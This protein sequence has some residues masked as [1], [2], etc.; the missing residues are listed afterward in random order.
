MRTDSTKSS[1]PIPSSLT[2]LEGAPHNLLPYPIGFDD[3]DEAARANSFDK[4]VELI[5][6]GNDRLSG[7]I[8]ANSIGS[9][10]IFS[11]VAEVFDPRNAEEEKWCG[12]ER[13]QA[14]YTLVR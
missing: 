14:M 4:L 13:M 12:E 7:V 6:N 11:M 9:S 3:E 10:L 5:E 1:F 2:D 8:E